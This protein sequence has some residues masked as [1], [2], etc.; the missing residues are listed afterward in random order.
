MWHEGLN[1][2]KLKITIKEI[3]QNDFKYG[4]VSDLVAKIASLS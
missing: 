1:N 3:M 4:K 2:C